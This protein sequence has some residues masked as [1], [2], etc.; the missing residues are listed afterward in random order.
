MFVLTALIL[1]LAVAVCAPWLA[2]HD[3]QEWDWHRELGHRCI[4]KLVAFD[5]SVA[6]AT[7]VTLTTM[8]GLGWH[9]LASEGVVAPRSEYGELGSLILCAITAAFGGGTAL[10]T[11]RLPAGTHPPALRRLSSVRG[12]YLR[13][14]RSHAAQS[15]TRDHVYKRLPGLQQL[16][17]TRT[18]ELEVQAWTEASKL[19]AEDAGRLIKYVKAGDDESLLSFAA[20]VCAHDG[21]REFLADLAENGPHRAAEQR[22]AEARAR[23]S[24]AVPVAKRKGSKHQQSSRRG[25]RDRG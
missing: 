25:R 18:L 7:Y 13:E 24:A 17:G 8:G 23:A 21:G 2:A 12:R 11:A 10:V 3:A 14:I 9:A 6:L 15:Q 16:V 5:L 20:S 4:R 22:A 1:G 19:D